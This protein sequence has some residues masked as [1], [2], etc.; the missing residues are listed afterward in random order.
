MYLAPRALIVEFHITF[1]VVIYAVHVVSSEGYFIR[2]P[3]AVV[4][5]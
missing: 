2:S 1:D 3:L 5:T 4:L